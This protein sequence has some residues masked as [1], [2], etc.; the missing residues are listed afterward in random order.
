MNK[1]EIISV[2]MRRRIKENH[3]PLDQPIPDEISL[4]KEFNCSRM[5]MKRALDILVMEGL[6]FRKRG[7]GTFIVKSAIQD[8]RI[9]VVSNEVLGFS[10][11]INNDKITSKVI[12]FEV[13]FPSEEVAAHLAIDIKTPVYF[14]IRLRMVD[15]EPYVLEKTYM[16]TTLI[17]G[18]N[19]E[20]LHGSVYDYIM[21]TLDLTIAGSHRKVRACKSDTLDQEHLVCQSDDPILE[22]EHVG[23]LNNGV[24][25]EYSFSRH[26]YDKFEVTTVNLR[27]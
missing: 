8:S 22:V 20:I 17:P 15:G 7:H 16:P 2:E 6:L 11:L 24:P 1:Y 21:N 9:N 13:H 25:F 3:Y 27:G 10:K 19:D 18:I 4:S 26:R 12:K 23:F 14:I 5:T